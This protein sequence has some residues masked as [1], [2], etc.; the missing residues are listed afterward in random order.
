[1]QRPSVRALAA[2]AV[3]ALATAGV[4]AVGPAAAQSS[5]AK[6]PVNA[7]KNAKKPV[8]ITMWHS[9]PRA[10][11]ETLQS[12][13]TDFEAAQSDVTVKLVNQTTYRDTF[14]KYRAGLSSG[15]L[16][17][18]VQIEDTGLQQMIDTRSILPVTACAKA[19]GYEFE[20]YVER[21]LDYYT[22]EGTLWPM[23]FNVSNPVL[24]YNK[25]AFRAAGLDPEAPPTTLDQVTEYSQ[26][27]MDTGAVSQAGFGLKL[28][29]WYL[30]QWSAKGG[31]LYVNNKNG[32]SKRATATVFDNPVGLEIFTWLNDM[33]SSG[34]AKTNDPE[35]PSVYDN[36]LGIGN[37]NFGM[38]IDTSAALGTILQVLS[39]GQY[40]DVE[41]G[42]APMPGPTGKGGVLVGGAALYIP[43]KS[44]AAKQAAAWEFAKFLNEPASQAKWSVG[45]GYVPIRESSVDDPELQARW[46]EVPGYQVAYDQLLTGVNNAATAGPVI[47]DYQGVRDAL[48]L[49]EQKMFSSGKK[50]AAALKAA[51]K[52]TTGVIQAYNERLG[53]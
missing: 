10:N 50:P 6:C 53:V 14:D 4:T 47:G 42:V 7:L 33:V 18:L 37:K 5:G 46:A 31:K 41:L 44:S 39:G 40:A 16:P 22:V 49:E 35:G 17:D 36:L 28:D 19:D 45:T 34:L 11:E 29:P 27:L 43:N 24:Y 15:D 8:Q 30:E 48:I 25:A 52:S 32:R 9:M 12:L 21:V 51:Q 3:A 2:V 13:V 26:Q 23:P 38:T 1:M 20:D